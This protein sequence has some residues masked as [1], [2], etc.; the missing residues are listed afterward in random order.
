MEHEGESAE[1]TLRSAQGRNRRNVYIPTVRRRI[2]SITIQLGSSLGWARRT[3][4]AVLPR[5]P[6]PLRASKA[7]NS[8]LVYYRIG[9]RRGGVFYVFFGK[10]RIANY[11]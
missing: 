3:P 11:L 9:G 10:L 2:E 6:L 7:Y 1:G 4:I 5:H 8:V